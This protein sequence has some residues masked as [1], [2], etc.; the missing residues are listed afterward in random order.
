MDRD[1]EIA[2]IL[3]DT[4]DEY[5]EMASWEV[6]FQDAI[7]IPFEATLL[8]VSVT[9]TGFRANNSHAIQCRVRHE[10]KERWIG[11]EDLDEETIPNAM[12]HLLGLFRYWT[13]EEK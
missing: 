9:V 5:E 3:V 10:K 12:K 6:A 1:E 8:G 7:N 2:E 4:Y 13:G 11:V